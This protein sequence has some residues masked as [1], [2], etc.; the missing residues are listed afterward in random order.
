MVQD[1]WQM[2]NHSYTLQSM[3]IELGA[4]AKGK[5][6]ATLGRAIHAQVLEWINL[7]NS[8]LANQVHESQI[9]P[10]SLS[11][12]LGNRR[13]KGTEAGDNFYF[14]IGLLNG[15]LI[16]PLLKGIEIWGTQPLIFANF[17]FVLRNYYTLPGTHRLAG[18]TNY[19]VLTQTVQEQRKITLKFL[20]PTSFKQQK[21][22]QLF[23]L[24]DLV[25]GSLQRRWNEFAP[26]NLQIP[27]LTW[28]ALVTAYEL[29]TYALKLE[30]GAEIGSQGWISYEFNSSEQAKYASVLSQFAF[31]AGVGRKTTMGMGQVQ[32]TVNND[33]T[34]N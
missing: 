27:A 3:V 9:A 33:I 6:P 20:S 13:P 12:L 29:K 19:Y 25:F 5:P 7:G 8:E 31:F 4:A 23:P 1:I 21:S 11:G 10:L 2:S 14:R 26:E 30:S 28:D 32:L 34:I 24:S 22:I 15:N 17:P 18:A 16:E